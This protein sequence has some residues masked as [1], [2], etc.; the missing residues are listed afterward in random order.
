MAITWE[1]AQLG[2]ARAYVMQGNTANA[3]A[4][5]DASFGLWKDADSDIPIIQQAT[6]E[7]AKLE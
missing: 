6:A 4:A 2:L 1:L 7:Y 3:H 5:Y